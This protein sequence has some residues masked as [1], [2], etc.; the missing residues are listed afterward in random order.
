[1]FFSL[2]KINATN[3]N[4]I[5]DDYGEIDEKEYK[6]I[7]KFFE[8][9]AW[10]DGYKVSF[11]G[12]LNKLSSLNNATTIDDLRGIYEVDTDLSRFKQNVLNRILK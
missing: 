10:L 1:M 7:I 2:N 8:R 5:Y 12:Q 6:Y 4:L 11:N 9:E 3:L